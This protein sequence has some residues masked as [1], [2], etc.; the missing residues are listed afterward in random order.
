MRRW[1]SRLVLAAGLCVAACSPSATPPPLPPSEEPEAPP[2]HDGPLTDYVASAGLRWLVVG[3]PKKLA[4]EKALSQAVTRLLPPSGLDAYARSSGVDLRDIPSAMAAGF[5]FGTLYVAATPGPNERVE[6]LFVERLV[7]E[8]RVRHPHPKI[9]FVSGIIGQTPEALVRIEDELVAVAVGDPTP[10]KIVIL[11]AQGK[12]R[13]SPAALD[14]AALSTLPD[15]LERAPV[16][17]YFPGP[18]EGEW[19][20]GARGLIGAAV[21]IGGAARPLGDDAVHLTFY[22]SGDWD[23]VGPDATARLLAAWEDLATSRIGRLLGIDRPRSAPILSVSP[24]LLKLQIELY[25]APLVDGLRAAVVA[26]VWEMMGFDRV[27]E[28]PEPD[29]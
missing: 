16:R 1:G 5:D 21:A 3:S 19:V 2:L 14:G 27:P 15:E 26:D 8:P 29:K 17:V 22:L 28:A 7:T 18:F 6:E 12:L 20:R 25:L 9:R 24:D 13:R 11:Y 10:A 4:Q 23:A